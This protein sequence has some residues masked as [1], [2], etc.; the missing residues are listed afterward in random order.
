MARPP[1]GNPRNVVVAVRLTRGEEEALRASFG[2]PGRG[3]RALLDKA[4]KSDASRTAGAVG[5]RGPDMGSGWVDE[6]Q[7]IPDGALEGMTGVVRP[8]QS[9]KTAEA[10]KEIA[11][12]EADGKTVARAEDLPPADE[13]QGIPDEM[14]KHRHKR[15][16]VI[17]TEHV[18]GQA[19][20]IYQ[21]A[22]D[23]CMKELR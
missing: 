9:G 22:V 15:G 10:E 6:T 8:R 7:N 23:D 13:L 21:C 16:T 18:A 3:V 20:K 5:K 2:T 17:R 14:K 4:L 19:V 11:A 1:S 12:A